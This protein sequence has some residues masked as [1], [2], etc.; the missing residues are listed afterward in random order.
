MFEKTVSTKNLYII[1]LQQCVDITGT[2]PWDLVRH[3]QEMPIVDFAHKRK[4]KDRYEHKYISVLSGRTYQFSN[5]CHVGECV[6]SQAIPFPTIEKRIPL[7]ILQDMIDELSAEY[8]KQYTKE[9]PK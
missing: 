9:M 7:S 1:T 2:C 5:N 4:G 6:V 3:Y 8:Q